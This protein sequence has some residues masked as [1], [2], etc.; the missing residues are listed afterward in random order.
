[1][2]FLNSILLAGLAGI[3]IPILIHI[4]S[5]RQARVIEWGAMQF[6]LDTPV[7]MRRKKW[8]DHWLLMVVRMVMLLLLAFLLH[9]GFNHFLFAPVLQTLLVLLVLP[10]IFIFVFIESNIFS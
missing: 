10:V 3:A 7:K 9:S 6:L 8:I 2:I 4:F 5:K 1:M